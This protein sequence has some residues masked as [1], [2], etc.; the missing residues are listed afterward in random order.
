MAEDALVDPTT[1]AN[2]PARLTDGRLVD[3]LMIRF[4]CPECRGEEVRNVWEGVP[5]HKHTSNTTVVWHIMEGLSV[6]RE[7]PADPIP[8]GARRK[9][10]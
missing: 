6:V 5:L 9:G 7:S 3:A 4:R 10:P 1:Y 8:E 2:P